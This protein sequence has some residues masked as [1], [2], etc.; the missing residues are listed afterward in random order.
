[1]SL[2]RLP[3]GKLLLAFLAVPAGQGSPGRMP[4]PDGRW[5]HRGKG[6]CLWTFF[7]LFKRTLLWLSHHG[8]AGRENQSSNFLSGARARMLSALHL[9]LVAR[10]WLTSACRYATFSS[11][12]SSSNCAIYVSTTRRSIRAARHEW[13]A[14]FGA[15]T[16]QQ[17]HLENS[18]EFEKWSPGWTEHF[19]ELKI[20]GHGTVLALYRCAQN[21]LS[22]NV[23]ELLRRKK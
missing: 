17:D 22:A 11:F 8:K 16:P 15:G 18:Q 7:F 14:G 5:L 10:W 6:K 23:S 12:S 21:Q 2:L 20:C 19:Q 13:W 1:M 9:R 4:V 3:R